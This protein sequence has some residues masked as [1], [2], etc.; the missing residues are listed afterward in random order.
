M[1]LVLASGDHHFCHRGGHWDECL[2][3]HSWIAEQVEQLEPALF[4]SAGD[5]Y[6]RA[7]TPTE[8]AAVADWLTRIADVCPVVIAKGNHDRAQD[9][10]LLGR[11]DTRHKVIV[12]ERMGVHLV[13]GIAVAAMAWPSRSALAASLGGPA[14][15][16]TIAGAGHE[17]VRQGLRGLG[18]ALGEWAGPK[19]L[20]GHAHVVGATVGAH[21]QPLEVGETIAVGTTDL[22]LAGCDINVVGHIHKAQAWEHDG[23]STV[24]TGSPFRNSYGEAEGKSV[25][26]ISFNDAGKCTWM[27][28]GTPATPMVLLE[29]D[30]ADGK[31]L[32]TTGST[33]EVTPGARVRLR[34]SVLASQ[35]EAGK[36]AAE[37]L[38]VSI[39]SRGAEAVK[40]EKKVRPVMAAR[41][42]EVAEKTTTWEQLQAFWASRGEEPAQPMRDLLRAGL[43]AI[44]EEAA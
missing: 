41:A 1:T 3:L 11:L 5:V 28:I 35:Q 26:A 22:A 6:E 43:T 17:A 4:L 39:E 10:E 19:V 42:P 23:V 30:F 31:M 20:V 32:F 40:V 14:S 13:N 24:Y 16:A 29:A 33:Y 2:R 36:A 37:R 12:E 21:G 34:Y 25:L 44:E 9:L 15:A 8:R 7:S 27:R 18:Q 38:R